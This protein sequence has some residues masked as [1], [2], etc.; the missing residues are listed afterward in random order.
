MVHTNHLLFSVNIL[1]CGY[2]I[3][4]QPIRFLLYKEYI[5]GFDCKA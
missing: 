4:F 1:Q 2:Y 3:Q 5:S